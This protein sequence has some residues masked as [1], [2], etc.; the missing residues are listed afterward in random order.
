MKHALKTAG[1]A[2]FM[3]AAIGIG[4]IAAAQT[5]TA[6]LMAKGSNV[7]VGPSPRGAMRAMAYGPIGMSS[8]IRIRRIAASR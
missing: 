1:F 3:G 6:N 7:P 5:P 2:A 8:R 4:A